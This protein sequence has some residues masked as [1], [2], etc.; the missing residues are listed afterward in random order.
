MTDK[1]EG[2]FDEEH[3]TVEEMRKWHAGDIDTYRGTQYT[4]ED[5]EVCNLNGVPQIRHTSPTF[6]NLV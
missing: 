2:L 3:M 5:D 1:E 4:T 6:Y